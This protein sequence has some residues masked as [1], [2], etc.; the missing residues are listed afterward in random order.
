MK[1]YRQ[2][3][4][5]KE[6]LKQNKMLEYAI[7]FRHFVVKHK[8]LI[9]RSLLVVLVAAV[10]FAVF[11][12]LRQEEERKAAGLLDQAYALLRS[13]N[14]QEKIDEINKKLQDVLKEY[15]AS[16]AALR[17]HYYL[18]DIQY[19]QR[20]FKTAASNY[21]QTIAGGKSSY[22]YYM[23]LLSLGA[24]FS[25]QQRF[26]EALDCYEKVLEDGPESGFYDAAKLGKFRTHAAL[27]DYSA[28][29]RIIASLKEEKSPL[30][31]EAEKWA[32][33]MELKLRQSGTLK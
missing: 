17:A 33:Y 18:G 6:E 7:T 21:Q 24:S 10:L 5:S 27:K 12:T 26:R 15:P 11:A 28:A 30:A 19:N 20:K 22:F 25:Q 32:A 16:Q 3:S 4:M 29:R 13:E 23:A 9:L 2:A 14:V 8:Q 1:Q 31:R